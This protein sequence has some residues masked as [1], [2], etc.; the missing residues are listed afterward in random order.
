MEMLQLLEGWDGFSAIS[1]I[2]RPDDWG[3]RLTKVSSLLYESGLPAHRR[4]YLLREAMT[5]SDFPALFGDILDRSVLALYQTV[6]AEWRKITKRKVNR[7][8]RTARMFAIDG[9]DDLLPLIPEKSEYPASNR[10]EI[11]YDLKVYKMGRQF[12]ISWE[13]LINDDLGALSD[14]PQRF[15]M[16]V[17]N[18]L[19]AQVITAFATNIGAVAEGSGGNLYQVGLNASDLP[20]TIGNL[21]TACSAMRQFR[22]R[23][24]MPMFNR[25][26]YLVV[27]PALEFTARQILTSAQH[28]R[29]ATG[30]NEGP[31]PITNVISQYGLELIVDDFLP[32]VIGN[33]GKNFGDT[34]WYLF[35]D[36][37]SVPSVAAVYLAGHEN[38]EICMKSSNKVSIGGGGDL[39]PL[40][41]D[42]ETDNVIYRLRMCFHADHLDWRGTWM[43]TGDNEG[44]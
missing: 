3:S 17:S 28:M 12:D 18:T 32:Y 7:D 43:S 21:Q 35:A 26:K 19:H 33:L 5:T 42:I 14:T 27:P 1:E 20:L 37:A 39:G 44:S 11:Y 29:L 6:P 10:E 15:A 25:A 30:T 4:E 38:P 40:S 34:A 24:G 8:F 23:S 16:A 31:W 41:G 2:R 9:G 22:S 36:P 13:S